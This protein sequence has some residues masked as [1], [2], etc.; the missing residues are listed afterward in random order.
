MI[1]LASINSAP[2]IFPTQ[3]RLTASNHWDHLLARLGVKRGEHRVEPGL[4]ALGISHA[5]FARFRLG[6]LHAQL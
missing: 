1:N 4:Y 2:T 6:Q 5:R 3:S